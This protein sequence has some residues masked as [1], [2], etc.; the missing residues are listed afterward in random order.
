MI[1]HT[2]QNVVQ[3]ASNA[4]GCRMASA[5]LSHVFGQIVDCCLNG[6]HDLIIDVGNQTDGFQ[7]IM[8][9]HMMAVPACVQTVQTFSSGIFQDHRAA[10]RHAWLLV[11][12]TTER[13][14]LRLVRAAFIFGRTPSYFGP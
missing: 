8:G 7:G 3:Q 12:F 9:V 5:E 6:Q 4:T 1:L 13:Q 11:V 10:G 2:A 14:R